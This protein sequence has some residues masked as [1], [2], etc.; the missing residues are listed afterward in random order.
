MQERVQEGAPASLGHPVPGYLGAGSSRGSPGAVS[1]GAGGLRKR[2]GRG[3]VELGEQ[4]LARLLTRVVGKL[5]RD[6][7]R[8]QRLPPRSVL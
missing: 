1:G 6:G 7:A 4:R 8:P 2:P 5:G 3:L